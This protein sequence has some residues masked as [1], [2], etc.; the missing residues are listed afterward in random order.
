MILPQKII[1]LYRNY[2]TKH[3]YSLYDKALIDFRQY[4]LLNTCR[5]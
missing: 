2:H 5:E 3:L 4:N 1:Q